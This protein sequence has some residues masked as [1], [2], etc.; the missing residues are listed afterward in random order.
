MMGL[1][2]VEEKYPGASQFSLAELFS[3]NPKT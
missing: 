3:Q 2:Q 1:R